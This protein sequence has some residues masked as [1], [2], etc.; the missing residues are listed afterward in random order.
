MSEEQPQFDDIEQK[1]QARESRAAESGPLA[2]VGTILS[3]LPCVP[4]MEPHPD[5]PNIDQI[6]A[7]FDRFRAD[8]D[9]DSS[10]V[11]RGDSH[12]LC[13]WSQKILQFLPA[14]EQASDSESDPVV[15][16][17]KSI[18]NFYAG[19]R[20]AG[21]DC[22]ELDTLFNCMKI[23]ESIMSISFVVFKEHPGT[24]SAINEQLQAAQSKI[25]GHG[26]TGCI[27]L[28]CFG[29]AI[30]SQFNRILRIIDE[31]L[32]EMGLVRV[33]EFVAY[34]IE[35][36]CKFFNI[37]I[38][39][40]N[41][42]EDISNSI[43]TIVENVT[44]PLKK[45]FGDDIP[46]TGRTKKWGP[47]K[48]ASKIKAKIAKFDQKSPIVGRT[49]SSFEKLF[50][51]I[52][53]IDDDFEKNNKS[54]TRALTTA[55]VV[56]S[57]DEDTNKMEMQPLLAREVAAGYDESYA[58]VMRIGRLFQHLETVLSYGIILFSNEDQILNPLLD[59]VD[60]CTRIIEKF[61]GLHLLY[62]II[63]GKN[64]L[65]KLKVVFKEIIQ[66]LSNSKLKFNSPREF[67]GE[68]NS[69]FPNLLYLLCEGYA[70][71]KLKKKLEPLPDPIENLI[72]NAI[73]KGLDK[74]KNKFKF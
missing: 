38:R 7:V 32:G 47:L 27:A 4:K 42:L 3:C 52:E 28:A 1:A 69:R 23:Y 39:D 61:V 2:V 72:N 30:L 71:D 51:A 26:S 8:N 29:A 15:S 62:K 21:F 56:T 16:H 6:R 58:E 43:Q 67:L 41:N 19:V 12:S 33:A 70:N 24:L 34:I 54:R 53:K 36:F 10:F 60:E 40:F 13:E 57:E 20:N 68:F 45:V 44:S 11:D 59:L 49:L 17:F 63:L 18:Q 73:D 22:G 37:D 9:A 14:V 48:I 74:I 50:N 65:S 25:Q 66:L 55:S 64:Y 35:V 31:K 46:S 5:T